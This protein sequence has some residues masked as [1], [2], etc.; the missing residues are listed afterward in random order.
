V[1]FSVDK[2]DSFKSSRMPKAENRRGFSKANH[3]ELSLIKFSF[4]LSEGR[5]IWTK[6]QPDKLEVGPYDFVVS[7]PL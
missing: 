6:R 5:Y 1:R 4:H 3:N 7:I 2:F